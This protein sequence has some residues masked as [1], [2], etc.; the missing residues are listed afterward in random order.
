MPAFPKSVQRILEL[1]REESLHRKELVHR[2]RPRPGAHAED[3]QGR[4]L[5]LFPPA[6]TD[7]RRSAMPWFS[8]ASTPPRTWRLAWPPSACCRK[9]MRPDST[10]RTTWCIRWPPLHRQTPGQPGGG[11]RSD[12]VFR[13]RAA[14]RLRQGGDGRS[15]P[16]RLSGGPGSCSKDGSSLHLALQ[17][18]RVRTM[19]SSGPC[20]WRA[21][22]SRS[23]WSRP[24][25]TSL[26][27]TCRHRMIACVFGANQICKKLNVSD[28][29]A[30]PCFGAAAGHCAT[31]GRL[32][33]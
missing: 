17:R 32:A 2:D 18:H 11:C 20:W 21:G 5:G 6:Q 13:G 14:A 33:G 22:A 9:T 16:Q 12:G 31:P 10:G 7:Q 27:T 26:A 25:G 4:Q 3:A 28:R 30:I 19:P 23:R 15:M 1:A 24:S 29:P 8:W